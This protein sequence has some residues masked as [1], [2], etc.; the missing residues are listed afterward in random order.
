MR[1][2]EQNAGAA[3]QTPLR[4]D[5]REDAGQGDQTPGIVLLLPLL[6]PSSPSPRL[7]HWGDLEIRI[8]RGFG[9]KENRGQ[10]DSRKT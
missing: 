5:G 7:F 8:R 1:E 3:R 6:D 4:E 9:D 10:M 2:I